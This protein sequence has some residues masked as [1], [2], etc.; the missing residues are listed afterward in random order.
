M[1]ALVLGASKVQA[2]TSATRPWEARSER[3]ERRASC[4][5]FLG[6]FWA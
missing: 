6:V 4:T 1:A 3:A 5:I 2:S